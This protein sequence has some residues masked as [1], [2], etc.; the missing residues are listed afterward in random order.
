ME[1]KEDAPPSPTK[2]EEASVAD[3]A[4][5][6]LSDQGKDLLRVGLES[7]KPSSAASTI[8]EQEEM[9]RKV[10]PKE[11]GEARFTL[12]KPLHNQTSK[13]QME[14]A[15]SSSSEEEDEEDT[16]QN[17]IAG[18]LSGSE[19]RVE[20]VTTERP[21]RGLTLPLYNPVDQSQIVPSA[22]KTFTREPFIGECLYI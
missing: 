17:H 4:R 14:N 1:A 18:F 21:M 15:P 9:L 22:E 20:I 7:K 11:P 16:E 8:F 5:R 19:N 12:V 13:F 2:S 3:T 6:R 10:R